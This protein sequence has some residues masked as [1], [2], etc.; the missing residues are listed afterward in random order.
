MIDL[1][2]KGLPNHIDVAGKSYLLDTDFRTWIS[3]GKMLEENE[4]NWVEIITV[5]KDIT[6]IE[7]FENQQEIQMKL[8]EFY[9]NP[10]STPKGSNSDNI[11]ILDYIEDGEYIIGSFMSAYNIDLTSCDMHWHLFKALF[12]S[13]PEDTKIK[14]IMQ[15]RSYK[16]SNKSY[17][18]QC[19]E[20]RHTWALSQHSTTSQ[21]IDEINELF[22]NS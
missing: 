1:R 3:I 10:N 21:D 5:I 16:K 22:Y 14:Q 8:I 18:K 7:F 19:E 9:T 4:P 6:V 13:L 11:T 12:I 2:T 15:F 17:D 20:M